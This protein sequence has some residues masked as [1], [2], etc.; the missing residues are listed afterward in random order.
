MSAFKSSICALFAQNNAKMRKKNINIF[1]FISIWYILHKRNKWIISNGVHLIC[2][3]RVSVCYFFLLVWSIFL[4]LLFA[5]EIPTFFFSSIFQIES[6][7][8]LLCVGVG[9]SISFLAWFSGVEQSDSIKECCSFGVKRKRYRTAL[10][11]FYFTLS[12][13]RARRIKLK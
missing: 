8:C 1:V 3:V 9:F 13:H 10:L 7:K 11:K 2:F 6:M 5:L 12:T 4:I